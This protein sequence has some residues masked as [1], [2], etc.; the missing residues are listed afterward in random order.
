M[1]LP[2]KYRPQVFEEVTGQ[3]HVTRTLQNALAQKKISS[4]YLLSGPRGIGK[5]TIARIFAKG[6]NCEKGITPH[7]CNK[8]DACREI[9]ESRSLNVL[10][11]DGASNRGIDDVRELREKILYAPPTGRFRVIIIDEV[12]MLSTPAFNALLKTLE[13]PPPHVVFIFATTEPQ[14]VPETVLS[15]TLRFDLRPLTEEQISGR[16]K[17][18][19]EKE[20]I[21][22]DDEAIFAIAEHARGSLRDALVLLEQLNL[23]AEGKIVKRHVLQ[24]LGIVEETLYIEILSQIKKRNLKALF[25]TLEDKVFRRGVPLPTFVSG[26]SRFLVNLLRSR[27]GVAK[28]PSEKIGDEFAT[29]DILALL[30]LSLE[31]EKDIRFSLMPKVWLNYYM[32]KMAYLPSYIEIEEI[33]QKSGINLF[34]EGEIVIKEEKTE[35]VSPPLVEETVEME[36]PLAEESLKEDTEEVKVEGGKAPFEGVGSHQSDA[37]SGQQKRIVDNLLSHLKEKLPL[38]GTIISRA[39]SHIRNG[40]ITLEVEDPFQLDFL[41][42]HRQDIEN[43]LKELSPNLHQVEIVLGDEK[44]ENRETF[45]DVWLKRFVEDL[46]MEVKEDV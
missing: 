9:Q 2:I 37:L 36:A 31:M 7:P 20:D 44:K 1:N 38:L 33:L 19:A 5:T 35:E 14:K 11:I 43:L 16:L 46:D 40:T 42:D 24:L 22:I 26:F 41:E 4:A 13:E 25:R 17:E 34:E 45:E 29:P 30:S 10:E 6:L 12:H 15:R 23:F 28:V 3:K 27:E 39:N 8:C 18:I 21:K 32:A